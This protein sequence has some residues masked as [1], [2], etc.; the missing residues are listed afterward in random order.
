LVSIQTFL[1]GALVLPD[2]GQVEG[3]S[4]N[5]I[6]LSS[7]QSPGPALQKLDVRLHTRSGGFSSF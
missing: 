3:S 2:S 1:E 7:L 6:A 4:S 5:D